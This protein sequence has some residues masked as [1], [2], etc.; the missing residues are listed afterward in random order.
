[1]VQPCS[2]FARRRLAA[3]QEF[4]DLGVD[5]RFQDH[6]RKDHD[7]GTGQAG[8]QRSQ[9]LLAQNKLIDISNAYTEAAGSGAEIS[10]AAKKAGMR[11]IHVPAIDA[12]GLAPDGTKPALPI[13]PELLAQIFTAEVGE[14]GDPFQTKTGAPM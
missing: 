6:T 12:Q 14:S 11:L 9:N 3:T 13:D 2:R 7:A 5:A 8:G 10:Q 4:L 1:M